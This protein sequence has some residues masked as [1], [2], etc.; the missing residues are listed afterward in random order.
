MEHL[1]EPILAAII[2]AA[3]T[4]G[5]AILQIF[6]SQSQPESR[7]KR[8]KSWMYTIMLMLA[9]AVGGF[10][11]AEF[12]DGQTDAGYEA[13]SQKLQAQLT[14]LSAAASRAAATQQAAGGGATTLVSTVPGESMGTAA[15]A[16]FPACKGAIVGFATQPT[17]CTEQNALRIAVCAAVPASAKVTS[18]E[19]YARFNDAQSWSSN[20]LAVGEIAA[21]G[22]F[23]G[24]YF[25]HTD[26]DG[27][28]QVCQ[29]FAHW[30][31]QPRAARIVARYTMPSEALHASATPTS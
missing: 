19:T 15:V 26:S 4:F 5:T 28:K 3:A 30:G 25:E 24:S 9:C 7:A 29:T 20:L 8:R 2:G 17:P 13:L 14:E 16:A 21:E 18:V 6:R 1:S 12:R 11:Y 27:T 10:A 31:S 23:E 22:R